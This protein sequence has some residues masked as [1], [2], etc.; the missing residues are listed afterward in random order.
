MKQSTKLERHIFKLAYT[1]RR[2]C[3]V[4]SACRFILA[5]RIHPSDDIYFSLVSS[6]HCNYAALFTQAEGNLGAVT[7]KILDGLTP[8]QKALHEMILKL[9][10]KVFAHVDPTIEGKFPQEE[11]R[12]ELACRLNEVRVFVSY[13][14]QK[15]V[16]KFGTNET[17]A[18]PGGVEPIIFLVAYLRLA[19]QKEMEKTLFKR[20]SPKK[21]GEAFVINGSV[22]SQDSKGKAAE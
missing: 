19:V 9:R 11:E 8:E 10:N 7:I 12:E 2:L 21:K 15:Q 1:D 13:E 14:G 16:I 5:N 4:E 20:Y 18:L 22:F 3:H 6:I 17:C